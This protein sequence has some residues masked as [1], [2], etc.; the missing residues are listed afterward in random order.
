MGENSKSPK[1]V[2]PYPLE[3][4]IN[5][6]NVSFF[7]NVPSKSKAYTFIL[8]EI[9]L[10]T[11][12]VSPKLNTINWNERVVK[13]NFCRDHRFF[14]LLLQAECSATSLKAQKHL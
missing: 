7:V 13:E 12:N 8:Q 11:R 14:Y 5:S 4:S 1:K 10:L 6:M 2:F 9:Y 3:Y